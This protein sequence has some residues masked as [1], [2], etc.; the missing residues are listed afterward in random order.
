MVKDQGT[1]SPHELFWTAKY[2]FSERSEG[3][4]LC[5]ERPQKRINSFLV[6]QSKLWGNEAKWGKG[7]DSNTVAVKLKE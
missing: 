2:V 3:T 1:R 7:K 4:F 6:S 5:F